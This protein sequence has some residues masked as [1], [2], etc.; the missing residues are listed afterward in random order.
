MTPFVSLITFIKAI[1]MEKESNSIKSK[2]TLTGVK[3]AAF[4]RD[5]SVEE[6]KLVSRVNN[7]TINDIIMTVTSLS[8][9]QYLKK[10][11]D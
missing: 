1:I 7:V 8:L 5:I 9:S 10:S 3:Q 2:K 4:S 11:K 6:L